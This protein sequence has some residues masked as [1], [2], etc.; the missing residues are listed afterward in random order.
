MEMIIL[1]E[2]ISFPI[3]PANLMCKE[4]LLLRGN[5]EKK[6]YPSSLSVGTGIIYLIAGAAEVQQPLV[7]ASLS[8]RTGMVKADCAA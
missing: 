7:L 2:I 1:I 6:I 3:T 8:G 4:L 5:G